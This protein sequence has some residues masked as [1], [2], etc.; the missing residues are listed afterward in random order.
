MKGKYFEYLEALPAVCLQRRLRGLYL[1]SNCGMYQ[2]HYVIHV[3]ACECTMSESIH[4]E[5]RVCWSSKA[6]D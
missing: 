1:V 2:F 5:L 3:V 4:L 6:C